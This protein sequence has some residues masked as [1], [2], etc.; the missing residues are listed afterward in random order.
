[1][2]R[3]AG[4]KPIMKRYDWS[5]SQ[6]GWMSANHEGGLGVTWAMARE[7]L[8]LVGRSFRHNT[9]QQRLHFRFNLLWD[10]CVKSSGVSLD[11]FIR[12][13]RAGSKQA[14]LPS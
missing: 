4:Y 14:V 6:N 3:T 9:D 12:C 2:I 1:M 7:N 13:S 10:R 8:E 5:R 11:T